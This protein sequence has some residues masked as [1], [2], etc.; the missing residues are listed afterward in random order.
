MTV[1]KPEIPPRSPNRSKKA[2]VDLKVVI[3]LSLAMNE[4]E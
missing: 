3:G 1:K 4:T 2:Y